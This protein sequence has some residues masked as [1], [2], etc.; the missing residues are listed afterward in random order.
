[1]S[2]YKVEITGVNTNDLPVLKHYEMIELFKKFK[3][4]DK[5]AREKIIEGNYRLV[6]SLVQKLANSRFNM[7]DLFQIGCIG[8]TKAVDNFDLSHNVMFSTYAV[9][10]ISGE[11]K[12][13]IRDNNSIRR[14]RS[15]SELAYLIIR[16]KEEYEKKFNKEPS[17]EEI[18]ASL[19]ISEFQIAEA[20]DSLKEP[21][22]MYE[23]IYNSSGDSIYLEDQLADDKAGRN[24]NEIIA[25]KTAL[26]KVNKREANI[27]YS[28][29]IYGLTQAEIAS[30]L[31][32]SQAQVSRIEKSA[33]KNVR[34]QIN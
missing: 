11:I 13:Y 12:R 5:L 28:R 14:S 19:N 21:M 24:L 20:I 9:P 16:F 29:Y 6:L 26:E 31:N 32:I 4:G 15:L 10:M 7:D 3:N 27:L 1:M 30:E 22:S 8:L 18:S 33:I 2:K 23:P 34:R 25:L 17:S